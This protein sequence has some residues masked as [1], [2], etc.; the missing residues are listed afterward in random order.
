MCDR[1][2]GIRRSVTVGLMINETCG[3]HTDLVGQGTYSLRMVNS[4][5]VVAVSLREMLEDLKSMIH[6]G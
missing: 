1:A 6:D 4:M 5:V 2:L 3:C